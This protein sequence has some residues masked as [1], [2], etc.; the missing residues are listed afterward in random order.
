[1]IEVR[2]RGLQEMLASGKRIHELEEEVTLLQ[3]K[4]TASHAEVLLGQEQVKRF[5]DECEILQHSLAVAQEGNQEAMAL[6]ETFEKRLEVLQKKIFDLG[7]ENGGLKEQSAAQT[8]KLQEP[9]QQLMEVN[10]TKIQLEQHLL[11]SQ[12]LKEAFELESSTLVLKIKELGRE[13]DATQRNKQELLKQ[14]MQKDGQTSKLEETIGDMQAHIT[15]IEVEKDEMSKHMLR[16]EAETEELKKAR[17]SFL[18]ESQHY[19]SQCKAL[20]TAEAQLKEQLASLLNK[21]KCLQEEKMAIEGM[22]VNANLE[23]KEL[24]TSL[25]AI[26]SEKSLLLQKASGRVDAS[27]SENDQ[28]SQETVLQTNH[29]RDLEVALAG[30]LEENDM[31]GKREAK[32]LSSFSNLEKASQAEMA[33]SK[34]TLDEH[35]ALIAE[36]DI[37]L[38]DLIKQ[39]DFLEKQGRE[40]LHS[41]SRLKEEFSLL[42][43]ERME[44]SKLVERLHADVEE[45]NNAKDH[46][47]VKCQ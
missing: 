24:H 45:I 26:Y 31:L 23:V 42:E 2:D 30:L 8:V 16:L 15:Q 11:K 9:E 41:N 32:S 44:M 25:D 19:E 12:K 10:A 7:E 21:S 46:F 29:L 1:M 43:T 35:V 18:A 38:T 4:M 5:K 6:K 36:R 47:F 14:I 34:Q 20:E 37:S 28:L 39:K 3:Q 13:L 40:A 33:K 27:Q 17:I 22:L